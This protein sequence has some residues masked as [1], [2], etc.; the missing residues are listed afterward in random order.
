METT[1]KTLVAALT[2]S[3]LGDLGAE[4][5]AGWVE[6]INDLEGLT[7]YIT[8]DLMQTLGYFAVAPDDVG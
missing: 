8:F 4:D 5:L 7:V 3:H 6:Q 1:V 2:P